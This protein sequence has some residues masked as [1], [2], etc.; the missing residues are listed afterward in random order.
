[1]SF[2]YGK[3]SYKPWIFRL[4]LHCSNVGHM[5]SIIMIF[6]YDISSHIHPLT[7]SSILKF[8]ITYCL[9]IWS[10]FIWLFLVTYHLLVWSFII[11]FWSKFKNVN[12][13]S[14]F[15]SSYLLK[16]SK[17]LIFSSLRIVKKMIHSN[18]LWFLNN[19]DISFKL[20][21]RFSYTW[22]TYF[23]LKGIFQSYTIFTYFN[24]YDI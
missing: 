15:I 10:S 2:Y 16:D 6:Y 22:S 18:S 12:R 4:L 9:S 24:F 7:W 14:L 8:Q 1:M 21:F 13:I 20:L 17:I 11:W 23:H 5:I 19:I 3:F